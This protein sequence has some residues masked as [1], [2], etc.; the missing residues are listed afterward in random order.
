[1]KKEKPFIYP[2]KTLGGFYFYDVNTDKIVAVREDVYHFLNKQQIEEVEVSDDI[3]YDIFLLE[4]NGFLKSTK[5][6]EIQHPDTDI[7]PSIL[8]NNVNHIILQVTQGCNLR[9]AYCAY[10]GHYEHREHTQ[11]RMNWKMAK[12]AIDFLLN[13]SSSSD[14]LIL[15]FYGGEPLLEFDLIKKCIYYILQEAEGKKVSFSLTTNATLLTDE[16]IETFEKY[17][18][19]LMISLDGPQE[20]HDRNRKYANGKGSFETVIKNVRYIKDKYPDYFKHIRFNMVVDLQSDL[21]VLRD[22][23]LESDVLNRMNVNIS[24][25]SNIY[26][27]NEF[28]DMSETGIYSKKYGFFEIIFAETWKNKRG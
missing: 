8:N 11:K 7:L 20:I 18:V 9:C 3:K 23:I 1:M 14:D 4:Q 28:D 25:V 5:V 22:F 19:D 12:D 6:K 17:S 27:K 13:H 26:V 15:G 21:N 2:F 10:S 16:I 24:T